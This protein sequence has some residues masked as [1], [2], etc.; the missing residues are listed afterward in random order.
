MEY[1]IYIIDY[2]GNPHFVQNATDYKTANECC[3]CL[4]DDLWARGQIIINGTCY[5]KED[6]FDIWMLRS[7]QDIYEE[8]GRT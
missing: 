4:F 3:D 2:R 8:L 5:Q 6:I 1:H 7:D